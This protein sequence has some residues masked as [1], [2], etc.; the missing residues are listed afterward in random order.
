MSAIKSWTDNQ[1]ERRHL[2]DRLKKARQEIWCKSEPPRY[3]V[4]ED[5]KLEFKDRAKRRGKR[6]RPASVNDR[7]E[8]YCF[9]LEL[10]DANGRTM[11]KAEAIF[12][13]LNHGWSWDQCLQHFKKYGDSAYYEIGGEIITRATA[14]ARREKQ[15]TPAHPAAVTSASTRS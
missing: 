11:T 3:V 7:W 12:Q 8:N 15:G 9:G 5:I 6:L 1:T 4:C 10:F 13:W 14:L 2:K